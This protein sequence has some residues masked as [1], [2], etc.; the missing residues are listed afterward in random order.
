MHALKDNVGP[1]SRGPERAHQTYYD[2]YSNTMKIGTTYCG[3][4]LEEVEGV[5]CYP[6]AFVTCPEC[7]KAMGE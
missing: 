4:T 6:S 7:L 5:A 1:L 3:K 2:P